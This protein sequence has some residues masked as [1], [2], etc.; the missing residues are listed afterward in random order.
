LEGDVFSFSLIVYAVASEN[1]DAT[2]AK[3][4]ERLSRGQADG[5]PAFLAQLIVRGLSR[6]PSERPSMAQF[7][8][9]FEECNFAILPGADPAE[10][11]AFAAW[12][13]ET[14]PNP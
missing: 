14:D 7:L 12:V 1:A 5:L 2:A 10:V 9:Q 3:A 13:D 11:S 6:D 8:C 4:V